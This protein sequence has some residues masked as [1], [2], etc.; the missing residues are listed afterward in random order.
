MLL[1]FPWFLVVKV[2]GLDLM[3]EGLSLDDTQISMKALYLVLERMLLTIELP[4][5]AVV[6]VYGK[7]FQGLGVLPPAA[8]ALMGGHGR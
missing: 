8:E 7:C 3:E 5:N 4:T 6:M 1:S 2:L